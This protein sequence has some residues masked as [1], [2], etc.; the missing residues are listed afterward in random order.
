MAVF[1]NANTMKIIINAVMK[2]HTQNLITVCQEPITWVMGS[3]SA[4]PRLS[5]S[6]YMYFSIQN[7]DFQLLMFSR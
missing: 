5:C 4:Y 7:C 6:K 2:F 1:G 3:W